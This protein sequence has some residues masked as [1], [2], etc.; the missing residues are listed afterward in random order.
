MLYDLIKICSLLS[1][2]FTFELIFSKSPARLFRKQPQMDKN[3]KILTTSS[4]KC[5]RFEI[6]LNA[7]SEI[8]MNN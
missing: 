1:L 8:I 7:V 4:I 5:N 6:F 2:E 3:L